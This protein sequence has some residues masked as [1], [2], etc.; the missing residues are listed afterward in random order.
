MILPWGV[1]WKT[2]IEEVVGETDCIRIAAPG[3]ERMQD[4]RQI[5]AIPE[6]Y[7]ISL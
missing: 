4:M 5:Q 7:Q 2:V 6:S 1:Q 3:T